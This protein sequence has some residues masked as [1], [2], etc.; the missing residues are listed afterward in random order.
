MRLKSEILT[1]IKA[2]L[3]S[4]PTVLIED[5]QTDNASEEDLLYSVSPEPVNPV[6][7]H[8][9]GETKM[10]FVF[11]LFCDMDRCTDEMRNQNYYN[12]EALSE[13]FS[14]ISRAR[15]F[16]NMSENLTPLKIEALSSTY[17]NYKSE[18]GDRALYGIQC[19]F[20]YMKK[21]Q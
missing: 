1:Y 21:E 3:S 13:W 17:E 12:Y 5:I 20:Y 18:N 7:K 14:Q 2:L 11:D 15:Q 19:A 10:Q 6:V 8:Y 4:C 9:F 16:P